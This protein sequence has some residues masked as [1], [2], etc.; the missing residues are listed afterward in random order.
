MEE[1]NCGSLWRAGPGDWS[2]RLSL[3]N[4]AVPRAS[5]PLREP[6]WVCGRSRVVDFGWQS[7]WSVCLGFLTWITFMRYLGLGPENRRLPGYRRALNQKQSSF[8]FTET[9]L[10]CSWRKKILGAPHTTVSSHQPRGGPHVRTSV[11]CSAARGH[12]LRSCP[13]TGCRPCARHLSRPILLALKCCVL[14][15]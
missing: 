6:L 3:W 4:A 2:L 9:V 11:A 12:S 10:R 14:V 5:V 1:W 13:P 7:D 8:T 15:V